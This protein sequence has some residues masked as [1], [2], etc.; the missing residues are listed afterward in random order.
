MS[1]QH[2]DL[3]LAKETLEKTIK[4]LKELSRI[5]FLDTF[6]AVNSKF[7]ELIP[8]L[9]SGG[10]GHLEL[11]NPEDPLQSGVEIIVR[12]PGKKITTMELMSG[13]EKALVAIAV[14]VAMFLHHPGPICV[15]DE[16]D[17]P[18][19][20]ANLVKL[21]DLLKEISDRTQFLVI[22]HNKITMQAVDRLIGITMQES[23]VTTALSVSLDEAEKQIDSMMANA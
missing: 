13:G 9:F 4:Q 7:K 21:L 17:A 11:L 15:L 16:I 5:R 18:L 1:T 8:R 12:P 6:T 23:G 20:D 3:T 2:K 10:S 14:L 22:T 19:D